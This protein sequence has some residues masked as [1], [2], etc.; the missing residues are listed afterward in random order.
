MVSCRRGPARGLRSRSLLARLAVTLA[1]LLAADAPPH[2][3]AAEHEPA[4]EPVR[5]DIVVKVVRVLDDQDWFGSGELSLGM[6]LLTCDTRALVDPC[7]GSKDFPPRVVGGWLQKFSADSGD[8]LTI[9]RVFPQPGDR[10][11]GKPV[12]EAVGFPAYPGHTY[13]LVLSMREDDPTAIELAQC[14][15][16]VMCD[17]DPQ[18]GKV[19]LELNEAGGWGV[20]VHSRARSLNDEGGP[21]AFEV[22]YE[23]RRTPLPDLWARGIQEIGEGDRAFY[24]ITVQNVGDQPL[25]QFPLTVRANDRVIRTVDP[26]PALGVGESTGH[27]VLRSE[28][29]AEKHLLSFTVDEEQRITELSERN[30]RYE[31]GIPAQ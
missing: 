29:P 12:A 17:P 3:A 7:W 28:L 8:I 27:C 22:T 4:R 11:S 13:R 30:N 14:F 23:V 15:T 16:F 31:W 9:D 25:A 10:L 1:C 6:A 19:E 26:M 21:G 18:L 20:G 2:P 24:C 5:L